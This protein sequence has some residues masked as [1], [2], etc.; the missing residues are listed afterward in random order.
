METTSDVFVSASKGDVVGNSDSSAITVDV[1]SVIVDGAI[2]TGDKVGSTEV[3][4]Y[5]GSFD[6]GSLVGSAVGNVVGSCV[7][8][9][10]AVG[11]SVGDEL[12]NMVEYVGD[13]VESVGDGVTT[14]GDSV[15]VGDG[16]DCVG[17]A[18]AWMAPVQLLSELFNDT[19]DDSQL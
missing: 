6:D 11:S 8:V 12:G 19:I 1:S 17:D 18:V 7:V 16:V 15:S 13:E 9:S 3:G 4:E 5:V 10:S 2:V 14:V